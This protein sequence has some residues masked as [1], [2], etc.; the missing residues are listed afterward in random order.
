M[1][2]RILF[3]D[4]HD[5]SGSC[6]MS[7]DAEDSNEVSSCTH[8][9]VRSRLNHWVDP[10]ILMRGETKCNNSVCVASVIKYTS[11]NEDE[12]VKHVGYRI[13]VTTR[14]GLTEFEPTSRSPS[15]HVLVDGQHI[16]V[17]QIHRLIDVDRPKLTEREIFF[18]DE[19]QIV[20]D[21]IELDEVF[22]MSKIA[23]SLWQ[24]PHIHALRQAEVIA[25]FVQPLER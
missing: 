15:H 11:T 24:R 20:C 2:K 10:D 17:N 25:A 19:F 22:F 3:A 4:V 6:K 12:L 18:L 13:L 21:A 16:I 1:P 5:L 7:S 9:V 14:L 8:A 23:E